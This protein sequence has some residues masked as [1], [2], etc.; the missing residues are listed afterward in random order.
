MEITGK[1]YRIDEVQSKSERFRKREFVIQRE[2]DG[3]N[4]TY[5]EWIKLQLEQRDVF[6]INDFKVGD[7]VRVE[8]E[9]RGSKYEKNGEEVFITNLKAVGIY[10]P[11]QRPQYNPLIDPH[12]DMAHI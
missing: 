5:S 1:I 11:A 4:G 2:K 12:D 3:Y 10:S 6:L 7:D 9:I 8:F